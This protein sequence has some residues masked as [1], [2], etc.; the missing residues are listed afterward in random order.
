M[1]PLCNLAK[2]IDQW[3]V[4][5]LRLRRESGNNIAEIRF[6]ELSGFIE[7]AGEKASAERAEAHESDS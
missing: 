6:V 7:L 2:Q 3:E 1:L 5:P 4:F